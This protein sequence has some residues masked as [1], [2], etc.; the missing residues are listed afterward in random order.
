MEV[1]NCIII[2]RMFERVSAECSAAAAG[3]L[4]DFREKITFETRVMFLSSQC[5]A[6]VPFERNL[7]PKLGYIANKPNSRELRRRNMKLWL[8]LNWIFELQ[9]F[10]HFTGMC[11]AGREK[12]WVDKVR[13]RNWKTFSFAS[14]ESLG[15]RRKKQS[16]IF[17][18]A[19]KEARKCAKHEFLL[20]KQHGSLCVR[21][22]QYK[23]KKRTSHW[24]L[25]SFFC[26]FMSR[27]MK[28]ESRSVSH[29]SERRQRKLSFYVKWEENWENKK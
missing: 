10:Q 18:S 21:S 3:L 13:T 26:L 9:L 4:L 29:M 19:D 15:T 23:K 24:F 20:K 22:P 28:K 17:I 11:F 8:A 14:G 2:R 16:K 7:D 5:T 6:H 27:G 25:C 12:R 1:S